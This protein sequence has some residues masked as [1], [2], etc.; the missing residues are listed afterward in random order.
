MLIQRF[1]MHL[2]TFTYTVGIN[3]RT[4]AME[5]TLVEVAFI[6]HTIWEGKLA[7]TFLPIMR[8]RALIFAA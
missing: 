6:D 7:L 3:K 4:I 2:A 5:F 1:K 8:F